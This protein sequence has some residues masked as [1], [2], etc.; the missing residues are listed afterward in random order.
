MHGEGRSSRG[1]NG[2]WESRGAPGTTAPLSGGRR[3]LRR[4]VLMAA[5]ARD[6]DAGGVVGG[7]VTEA[8]HLSWPELSSSSSMVMWNSLGVKGKHSTY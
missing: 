5:V 6:G 8:A 7:G 4:L 3:G 1:G 2:Q